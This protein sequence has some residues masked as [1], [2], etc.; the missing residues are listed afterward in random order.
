MNRLHIFN[1]D[2][3]YALAS[4][5]EYYTPPSSIV[6]LRMK[7][8]LLP[9]LYASPGDCILTLDSNAGTLKDLEYHDICLKK[10]IHIYSIENIG[11]KKDFLLSL[12][13]E[14]W[15]WNKNIRRILLDH[16]GDMHGIPSLESLDELRELSHRRTTIKFLEQLSE[17]LDTEISMPREVFN[18]EEAMK[19]Y[20]PEKDVFFKAPWSSSGRG[21]M[22][23]DDLEPYI[24]RPW[25]SGIIKKQGS[26]MAEKAYAKSLD[27]ATEWLCENGKAK[28]LGISVFNASRRGKYHYNHNGTQDELNR[29]ILQHTSSLGDELLEC[30]KNALENL[31]AKKYEGPVG[32]DMLVT[33]KGVINP[34][35]EINLRHTM[36][37]INLL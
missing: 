23:T 36:G 13:P 35:V 6:A 21:I 8:C 26:V 20:H 31:I 16:I 3:D 24:I 5:R 1:P 25:L 34:C 12:H 19:I 2:S 28:Y 30:Q 9:A 17:V 32:I 7:K 14:P 27:F 10:D 4:N 33:D 18:V 29:I 22:R 37:M 11:N 15:G